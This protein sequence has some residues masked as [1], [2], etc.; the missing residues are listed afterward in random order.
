MTTDVAITISTIPTEHLERSPDP[1]TDAVFFHAFVAYH[2][3][4][5]Q[6]CTDKVHSVS[7]L[8]K[9]YGLI[10]ANLSELECTDADCD[11]SMRC[12]IRQALFLLEDDLKAFDIESNL[13]TARIYC[14]HKSG[15]GRRANE[16][17]RN[18]VYPQRKG[19]LSDQFDSVY[20]EAVGYWKE[21]SGQK[22]A[23]PEKWL[24]SA[25]SKEKGSL[26][27]DFK[28]MEKQ[29]KDKH[30]WFQDWKKDASGTYQRLKDAEDGDAV[31]RVAALTM[32]RDCSKVEQAYIDYLR[33]I[34]IRMDDCE[35]SLEQ[36]KQ[37][38]P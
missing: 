14:N 37:W 9:D 13:Q 24:D 36:L 30:E 33:E 32:Q 12:E 11:K 2:R 15:T 1:V 35:E 7:V 17:L 4:E 22:L 19:L 27:D 5:L 10:S 34:R 23:D 25:L 21:L 18:G 31:R 26:T 8:R 28:R 16:A 6:N 38:F 3:V 29:A 20:Q